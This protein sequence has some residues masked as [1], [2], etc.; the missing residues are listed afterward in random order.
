MDGLSQNSGM[1]VWS[2]KPGLAIGGATPGTAVCV[3][4]PF[5]ELRRSLI[6]VKVARCHA[7]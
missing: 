6:R 5:K 3:A 2:K 4:A 1:T 7:C